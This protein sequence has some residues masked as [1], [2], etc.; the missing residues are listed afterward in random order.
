M[1]DEVIQI[2]NKEIYR[3]FPEVNGKK[4]KVVQQQLSQARSIGK[5][6][7]YLLTY[8]SRVKLQ[9]NKSLPYWVRVVVNTQGKILKL[10][11]SR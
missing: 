6:P 1:N 11:T 8:Q 5:Q 10:S 7:T 4:P 9:N 2:V 3:R